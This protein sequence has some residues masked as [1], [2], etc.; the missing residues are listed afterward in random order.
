MNHMLFDSTSLIC[1]CVCCVKFA[2]SI[3]FMVIIVG[4]A[5]NFI[6]RLHWTSRSTCGQVCVCVCAANAYAKLNFCKIIECFLEQICPP[7]F[8]FVSLFPMICFGSFRLGR[9]QA[10]RKFI[11]IYFSSSSSHWLCT[12]WFRLLNSAAQV[13][14]F[15]NECVRVFFVC[16]PFAVFVMNEQNPKT[17]FQHQNQKKNLDKWMT[18]CRM[19]KIMSLIFVIKIDLK[20]KQKRILWTMARAERKENNFIH[21]FE[22]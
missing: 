4:C 7:G 16:V 15:E 14:R 9:V 17:T 13:G 22:T 20:R 21:S 18:N 10:E 8:V 6:D 12:Y 11:V 2:F 1:V 19:S 3:H 5:L